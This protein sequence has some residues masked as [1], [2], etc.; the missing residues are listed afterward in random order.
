M[1][2]PWLLAQAAPIAA[3]GDPATANRLVDIALRR[4]FSGLTLSPNATDPG[5]SAWWAWS[6][7]VASLLLLAAIFQGPGRMFAQLFDFPGHLRVVLDSLGRFRR[8]G[9]LVAVLFGSL[10]ISWTTWQALRHADTRRLEDLAILIKAHPV[11][12]LAAEQGGRAALTTF[13]DLAGLAEIS[14]LLLAA[15][16]V[17]F[18]LSADRWGAIET[19]ETAP[20]T[21]PPPGTV[22]AWGAAWLY[23]LYR[24]ASAALAPDGWPLNRLLG[25]DIVAVPVLAIACDG[26]LFAWVLNELRHAFSDA[27]ASTLPAGVAEAISRWPAAIVACAAA[28]PARYIALLAWMILPY[29]PATAPSPIRVAFREIFR[30]DALLWIQAVSLPLTPLLGAAAW[31]GVN[32][33]PGIFRI[34]IA[35]LRAEGGRL[36]AVVLGGSVASAG[37]SALAYLALL[38]LPPQPWV[39]AAADG[40]AHYATLPP[41]LLL[42]ATLVELAGR[43]QTTDQA[44]SHPAAEEDISHYER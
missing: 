18:R 11:G 27:P 20:R 19:L 37:L 26:L 17:I 34:A 28:L 7:G 25:V 30:G 36:V 9:R 29:L 16:L 4:W 40:Y 23:L 3:G 5:H 33:R 32:G 35:L 1:F 12:D 42:L 2:Q 21:A 22:L 43:E 13:R 31:P 15:G 10:V 38:S 6:V 24:G 44:P 39:L 41:A 8:A 14:V